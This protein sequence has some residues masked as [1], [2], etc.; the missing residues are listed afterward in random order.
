MAQDFYEK[1]LLEDDCLLVKEETFN[2]CDL[3]GLNVKDMKRHENS[4]AHQSKSQEIKPTRVFIQPS[5]KGYQILS[6]MGWCDE[7]SIGGLGPTGAGRRFPVGTSLK[8]DRKGLGLEKSIERVT[9]FQAFNQ[10]AVES[11]K[12]PPPV[13]DKKIKKGLIDSNRKKEKRI[14]TQLSDKDESVEQYLY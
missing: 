14:R 7:T 9:H 5:N 2:K 3:C 13:V 11:S 8:R 6:K 12:I 4:I 10:Q 1:L